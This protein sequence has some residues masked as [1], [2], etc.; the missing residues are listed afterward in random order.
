MLTLKLERAEA[1]PIEALAPAIA[2]EE[3]S[4]DNAPAAHAIEAPND[5]DLQSLD[6][7]IFEAPAIVL[8]FPTFK[9]GRAFSQ[10]RRLREDFSYRG[11]LVARGDILPD[12]AL[13]LA[14]V[15]FTIVEVK[16][17]KENTPALFTKA[18]NAFSAPYQAASDAV[19]PAARRRRGALAA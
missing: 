13:F 17:P 4:P 9:D 18:L 2:L 16:D 14:R 19:S 5:L 3:W 6:P 10:A 11:E 7:R 12:Q 15:G 1:K 8:S